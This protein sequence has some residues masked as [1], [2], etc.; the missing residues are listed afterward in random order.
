MEISGSNAL[1]FQSQNTFL[2]VV[3]S[4]EASRQSVCLVSDP[5]PVL[6]FALYHKEWTPANYISLASLPPGRG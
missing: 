5:I 3:K 4:G 2:F 1:G 6:C